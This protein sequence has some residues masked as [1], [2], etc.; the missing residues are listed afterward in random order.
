M[1]AKTVPYSLVR[2]GL[3][4]WENRYFQAVFAGVFFGAKSVPYPQVG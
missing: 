4:F 2:P 3:N 1:K